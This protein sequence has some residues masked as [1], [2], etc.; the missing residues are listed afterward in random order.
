MCK[1]F[2]KEVKFEIDHK[3]KLSEG[4]TNKK[5]NLQVLC[6]A[7]HLI[8]TSNE[9]ETGQ[10]IKINDTKV[11]LINKFRKSLIAH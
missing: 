5:P 4:G 8:K 2:V 3:I 1:C 7:C 9:H 11:H 6:K 10:Y